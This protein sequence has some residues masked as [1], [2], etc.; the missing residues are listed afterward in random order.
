MYFEIIREVL[1]DAIN[2]CASDHQLSRQHVLSEIRKHI[3]HTQQQHNTGNSQIEYN[4]PLC[5]LGY[6]Y[7][8]VGIGATLFEKTLVD[9]KGLQMAV[10]NAVNGGTLSVCSLGG[11]PGT[12]LLGIGKY[13]LSQQVGVPRRINFCVLDNIPQWAE[14][15][16]PL[17]E[18]VESKMQ[19]A[20]GTGA[21]VSPIFQPIDVLDPDS[22]SDY[23]SLFKQMDVVV[24]NYLLSENK[25]H[26]DRAKQAIQHIA[27]R[28]NSG[29]VFV[30]I[31]RLEYTTNFRQD[32]VHLFE[33]ALG[34]AVE[35]N[36]RSG[37]MD[38]DERADVLGEELRGCLGFPR[39]TF[40]TKNMEPTVFWFAVTKS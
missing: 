14:T 28:T 25:D 16:T 31:D 35:V 6:L 3:D 22:Y 24:C 17:A 38:S 23:S 26:L 21:V 8:H 19:K 33:S 29:C 9:D 20:W 32:V 2:N 11:G 5:R 7:R 30:V 37:V 18:A 39:L 1:D 4:N 40:R 12:E 10:G 15:W 13:L 27:S 36:E 34:S